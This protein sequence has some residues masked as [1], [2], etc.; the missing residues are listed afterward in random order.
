MRCRRYSEREAEKKF[1]AR[2]ESPSRNVGTTK[3]FTVDDLVHKACRMS[4]LKIKQ[5]ALLIAK[6]PLSTSRPASLKLFKE[7]YHPISKGMV[8]TVYQ[9]SYKYPMNIALKYQ[10][11]PS[12]IEYL[13]NA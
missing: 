5:I 11:P 4:G 10:Q 2:M 6:D 7:M 3:A 1:V 13:L 8:T 12:V 9:E